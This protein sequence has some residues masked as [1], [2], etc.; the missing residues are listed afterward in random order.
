MKK[1]PISLLCGAAA[2]VVTVLLYFLLIP[3]VFVRGICLVTLCGVILAEVIVTVFAYLS[4]G[5]PRKVA[6]AVVS[7]FLIPYAVAL[8]FVYI[9]HF[10]CGYG[11]YAAWYITGVLVVCA[12]A[13][14]LS[15]FGSRKEEDNATLQNAKQHMLALRNLVK[16]IMA[17]PAYVPYQK[18][19]AAIEE[20]LHFTNDSVISPQDAMIESMLTEILRDIS[21]PEVDIPAKLADVNQVIDTRT[22][23][24]KYS[25]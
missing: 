9:V 7:A 3:N 10:P 13:V 18:E 24:T 5:E 22:I 19:L 15:S 14:I 20:K 12:L 2:V 4:N 8:S 25:V 21:N 23:M 17:N 16:C 1:M 6:S 11:T